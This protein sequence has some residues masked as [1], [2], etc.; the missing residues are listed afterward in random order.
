MKKEGLVCHCI[1]CREIQLEKF[2]EEDVQLRIIRKIKA[3]CLEFFISFN[4]RKRDKLLGLARLRLLNDNSD[5]LPLLKGKALIR[6]LHVHGATVRTNTRDSLKPQ[7]SGLGRRL[8]KKCEEIS[9]EHG[10]NTLCV[11]SGEGVI[12][13][14]EKRGFHLEEDEYNGTKYHYMIK[15]LVNPNDIMA[16]WIFIPSI[17]FLML[18]IIILC[19]DTLA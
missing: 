8:L 17:I 4:D 18:Y 2:N 12:K 1:R 3:D 19:I 7:H 13:Y 6:E 16:Y 10:Y 14:Y 9:L 15:N 11:T 5:C